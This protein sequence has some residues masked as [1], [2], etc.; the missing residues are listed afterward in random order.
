MKKSLENIFS[1][2]FSYRF[3]CIILSMRGN[4]LLVARGKFSG[5]VCNF[6]EE[7]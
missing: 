1:S 6:I 4:L 5:V 3:E 7:V 2:R